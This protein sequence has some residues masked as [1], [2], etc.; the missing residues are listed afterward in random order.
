MEIAT[1][2]RSPAGLAW[3]RWL[4]LVVAL[5]PVT[6]FVLLPI[7]LGLERYVVTG[8]SMSPALHRGTVVFERVVPASDVRVGDVVTF[9]HP[10]ESDAG[11]V[12]THRVVE[13]RPGGFVTRGDALS[14]RDPWIVRPTAA[15]VSRVVFSV[16]LVGW[17]YLAAEGPG[18]WLV[19]TGAAVVAAVALRRRSAPR[20]NPGV[21]GRSLPAPTTS[22]RATSGPLV[23]TGAGRSDAAGAKS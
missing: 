13:V 12:V 4:A 23:L 21:T 9:P 7:G 10:T 16:P 14:H 8:D 2:P 11:A 17:I 1:A 19:S 20:H 5:A 3:R 18:I 6:L 15:S 22:V